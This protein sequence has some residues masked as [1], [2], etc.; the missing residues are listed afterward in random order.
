[1]TSIS[2]DHSKIMNFC[3]ETEFTIVSQSPSTLHCC[4]Y[5]ER[6]DHNR[7]EYSRIRGVPLTG[8]RKK[9]FFRVSK[10]AHSFTAEVAVRLLDI[11]CPGGQ[12]DVITVF[13]KEDISSGTDEK[14]D[15]VTFEGGAPPASSL[16]AD[17]IHESEM[18]A[19]GVIRGI[20]VVLRHHGAPHPV[21]DSFIQQARAYLVVPD[22]GTFFK[23]A[24]YLT[25]APMARFLRNDLPKCPAGEIKF[26]GQFNKWA[27]PRFKKYC[28]KNIHLWYSF[29]QAKRAALPLSEE[30]VKTTYE[31]HRKAMEIEDP[32]DDKTHDLVMKVLKPHLK[33]VRKEMKRRLQS[34]IGSSSLSHTPSTSAC[35]EVPRSKGGQAAEIRSLV[36]DIVRYSPK[37]TASVRVLPQ[38]RRMTF[39]PKLLQDGVV[40][41]NV[42]VEEFEYS[43][44]LELWKTTLEKETF[45]YRGQKLHCTI[46]AV[47]EPLKI[48]VISKGEAVPYYASKDLQRALHGAMR[49]MDCYRLIGRPLCPTDLMDLYGERCEGG[50][51][52]EE[53]FSIDYSAATDNLSARL[54]QSIMNFLIDGFSEHQKALYRSVLA[55]HEVE[56]PPDFD[57]PPVTQKN[58][59]LMG[60]VLSFPILCIANLGLYLANI[61]DDTRPLKR[62]L[63]G[64]LVNGDD[65]LYVAKVSRWQNHIDL[66]RKVGLVMSPGKA[67]H[68]SRYANANSACFNYNLED[69]RATPWSI[70]FLNTGLYFN[71]SKVLASDADGERGFCSTINR[72][73]QG[74]LPGKGAELMKQ[75]MHKHRVLIAEECRGRNLFTPKSL[76]GMGVE[77]PYGFDVKFTWVQKAH[78]FRILQ[79][80]P[81]GWLGLGPKPGPAVPIAV[82]VLPPWE[83]AEKTVKISK[84]LSR[85]QTFDLL[86]DR[87]M[88]APLEICTVR[89]HDGV[90]TRAQ[91]K[92]DQ[93]REAMIDFYVERFNLDEDCENPWT[94][95]WRDLSAT[96]STG[97]GFGQDPSEADFEFACRFN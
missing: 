12:H 67:Y 86:S 73:L 47:I 65:M 39:Y 6:H 69:P 85:R 70:P 36:P 92:V 74:A 91:P 83:E 43:D 22:E 56:Y 59:Q 2:E 27:K 10:G 71:Q 45:A 84:S 89:C 53:W 5:T 15:S 58:G 57:I 29:L 31:E 76:G 61:V 88:E 30:L 54:S 18:R 63:K 50:S 68:H 24:K 80:Q 64:V 4:D 13:P 3:N 20:L 75:F 55:P 90:V 37:A 16:A 8:D 66:G 1:M 40:R 60:S 41:F 19:D 25:V 72:L 33:A 46:Q 23:R 42:T 11:V 14:G 81:F 35:Q 7:V 44:G 51:G 87:L 34:P 48:R 94:Q 17:S 52:P 32:I 49:E 26:T 97:L 78:A 9:E 96:L 21:V 79:D 28:Q 62:K 95:L 93:S 38:L 82:S 77:R